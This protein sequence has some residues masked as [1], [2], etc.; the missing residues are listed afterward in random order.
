MAKQSLTQALA[1]FRSGKGLQGITRCGLAGCPVGG[2]PETEQAK[3]RI[4]DE[5]PPRAM[6]SYTVDD[7]VGELYSVNH[8][9]R[10]E[11]QGC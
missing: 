5:L 4:A 11:Y 1:L 9:N 10:Y 8:A 6:R 3:R 2:W 7:V